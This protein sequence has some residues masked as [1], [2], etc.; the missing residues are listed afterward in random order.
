MLAIEVEFL[1]GRAVATQLND[2]GE[3]EWPPH[4]QR[5][6]SALVAVQSELGLGP[7]SRAALSWLERL[8]APEIR[9]DISP[10][11]RQVR[12]HWVPVNDE[13]VKAEKGR[14]DFRHP[15]ER[16]NRQERFFPAVVPADPVV[17]FQWRRA[18]GLHSHRE[19]LNLLVENLWYLGHS[20]SPIRA[21]LRDEVVDP[22]LTPAEDG[23]H[24]LRVP[25]PGRLNR[26]EGVH[27]LRLRDRS[28]QPPLGRIENYAETA[29]LAQTVFSPQAL[30]V[31]FDDGPHL[32]LDSTL[33]LMQLLRTAVLSHL[34]LGVP[35]SLT[36][37]EM[38]GSPARDPHVAFVPLAFVN[39]RHADGSLKGAA[40]V[41]PRGVQ[42]ESP[43]SLRAAFDR[44]RE[45]H[46]G[47]LG[48]ISMRLIE[49]PA[50]E[51]NSARFAPYAGP[52]ECWATVTPFVLDRHPKKNGPTAQ[53]IIEESCRRIGLPAPTEIHLGSVSVF[54]GVPRVQD[55]HGRAKQI[56]GRMR[57]HAL[58]RFPDRVHGPLLLGAG[59][60][61]G[62]GLCAP[63][64]DQSS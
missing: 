60:F 51:L 31:A 64:G 33:P 36:G 24:T 7:D 47:P 18:E 44:L 58:L 41:L 52:H 15:L 45:L 9:A 16:R 56:D 1:M 62:F 19:T 12:S 32:A 40:L 20:S 4:P 49:D 14:I 17:T 10:C 59:R 38:D 2:R 13:A 30:T 26:L 29:Q 55:F 8:P 5:L 6:F 23:D 61:V 46:L 50:A 21:C 48:S 42:P 25:G 22:T 54:R 53:S 43:R 34:G 35:T 63:F 57:T 37:H 11:L 3:A 28:V 27:Q 39:R